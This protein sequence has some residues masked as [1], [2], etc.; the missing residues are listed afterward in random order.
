MAGAM[1]A[2]S[3][4]AAVSWLYYAN[5]LYELP[6]GVVSVAIASVLVPVIAASVRAKDRAATASAQSRAFEIAFGLSLPSALAFALLAD[7]IAGGLFE[8]GAFGPRDTA[9][10]AGA[11]AAIC[12]GLPGHTLEKVFGA[13]SFAHEDTRT[14]M[15]AALAGLATALGGSLLL[16]PTHGHVGIAAAIA[17]SG[18]VGAAVLGLVLAR[19]RWL[20]VERDL[21]R[22]LVR[23]A[24][25][26]TAMA[27]VLIALKAAIAMTFDLAG[28][29][30]ARLVSLAVL[31]AS[32]LF[33]YLVGLQVLGVARLR[34]VMAS[35]RQGL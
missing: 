29:G 17:I 20:I 22:Q 14:P 7:A 30:F 26:A 33:V 6:L 13:V 25:A 11:L 28:S 31:V 32:G 34:D 9:A 21:W 18:W 27:V 19:R 15:F 2:S 1:V 12:A 4:Q 16:F 5:R 10:V 23:I 24:I 35:I 3:S 8:R